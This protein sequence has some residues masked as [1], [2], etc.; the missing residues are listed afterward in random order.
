MRAKNPYCS[1]A[2]F[3]VL[4]SICGPIDAV[5]ARTVFPK[6][7]ITRFSVVAA[8]LQRGELIFHSRCGMCHTVAADSPYNTMGPNLHG[9][10]GRKAGSLSSYEFSTA[11]QKSG[12][13]WRDQTLDAYLQNPH[14]EVP[15]V[16]M[17]FLGIS[18]KTVRADVIDY[19]RKATK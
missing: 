10:F 6:V 7:P 12:I 9:L 3:G 18:D 11:L 2:V 1:A 17:P 8:D 16:K 19:L 4:I 5:A 13:I 15:G 14:K